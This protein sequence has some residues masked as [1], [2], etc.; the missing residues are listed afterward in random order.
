MT[1]VFGARADGGLVRAVPFAL[2]WIN[3]IGPGLSEFGELE[4]N[5]KAGRN[6][7]RESERLGKGSLLGWDSD[8]DDQRGRIDSGTLVV[9]L[10]WAVDEAVQLQV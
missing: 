1:V 3:S 5:H 8:I 4:G 10:I 6:V 7:R 2:G 9:D